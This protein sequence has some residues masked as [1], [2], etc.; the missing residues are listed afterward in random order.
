MEAI[1]INHEVQ[2]RSAKQKQKKL[3]FVPL[4][5]TRD[6]EQDQPSEDREDPYQ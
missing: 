2:H 1:T 3:S 6:C 5:Q 4:N